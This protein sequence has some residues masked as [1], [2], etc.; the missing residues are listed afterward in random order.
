MVYF[1][2]FSPFSFSSSFSVPFS[3]PFFLFLPS[4]FFLAGAGGGKGLLPQP[5][6]DP[7]LVG[8]KIATYTPFFS[9]LL[10]QFPSLYLLFSFFLPISFLLS[11]FFDLIF[12]FYLF[13]YLFF[14]F[15]GGGGNSLGGEAPPISFSLFFSSFSSFFPF[16]SSFPSFPSLPL[17][18]PFLFLLFVFLLYFFPFFS[19]P[20]FPPFFSPFFSQGG[21]GWDPRP[22]TLPWIHHCPWT[23]AWF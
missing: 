12:F 7:Q 3:S 8:G 2:L 14:F 5:H 22:P 6:P 21:G 4:L 20:F 16:I 15:L 17:F 23:L 13:I 1:P 19:P 18:F 10:P 11:Y 9:F